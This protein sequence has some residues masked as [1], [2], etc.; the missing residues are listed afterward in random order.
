MLS[1]HS[2]TLLW[3]RQGNQPLH[4]AAKLT[5]VSIVGVGGTAVDLADIPIWWYNAFAIAQATP[6]VI[7]AMPRKATASKSMG[8][9]ASQQQDG[10][11]GVSVLSSISLNRKVHLLKEQLAGVGAQQETIAVDLTLQLMLASLPCTL[12]D[13]VTQLLEGAGQQNAQDVV[14]CQ[15]WHLWQTTVWSNSKAFQVPDAVLQ[16]QAVAKLGQ[17]VQRDLRLLHDRE[18]A[19]HVADAKV[20]GILSIVWLTVP[21]V[22]SNMCN[23]NLIGAAGCTQCFGTVA[24]MCS[25]RNSR[26]GLSWCMQNGKEAIETAMAQAAAAAERAQVRTCGPTICTQH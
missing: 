8:R 6:S 12:N 4:P 19:A 20:R 3:S 25:V 23:D 10:T 5:I 9:D 17:C 14:R 11:Q 1:T 15:P 22:H 18:Q 16:M 13:A 24:M 21:K 2:V 26:D 7:F